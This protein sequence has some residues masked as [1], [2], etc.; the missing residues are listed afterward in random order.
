M[1]YADVFRKNYLVFGLKDEAIDDIATLAEPQTYLAG[2]QLIRCGDR[3]CDLFV[4]LDGTVI[5]MTK[6]GDELAQIGPGS[7]LGEI[8]LVDDQP[9]SAEAVSKGMVKAVR[10]PA[11]D[12]RSYMAKHPETGFVMLANLA[13]VLSARLRK[14]DATVEHLAAHPK[15][16]W[17][18]AL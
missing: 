15:D 13:R 18:H 8:G 9:R 1:E 11:K 6:S 4:I 7:V 5:V 3:N 2:E 10:F 12:L 16:A 14:T 17:Q